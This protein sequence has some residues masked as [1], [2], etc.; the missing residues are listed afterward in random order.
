MVLKD[1]TFDYGDRRRYLLSNVD[2]AHDV[3][4]FRRE[5][6]RNAFDAYRSTGRRYLSGFDARLAA[7]DVIGSG[8]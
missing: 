7:R 6:R 1:R 8:A 4:T 2:Y 5:S 3:Q